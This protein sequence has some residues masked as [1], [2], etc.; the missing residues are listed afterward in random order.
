MMTMPKCSTAVVTS[1]H[2][3][4]PQRKTK[5]KEIETDGTLLGQQRELPLTLVVME[6]G[7]RCDESNVC[8]LRS[9]TYG[10]NQTAFCC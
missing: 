5:P 2:V 1:R 4:T 9:Q 7:D 3:Q 8:E 10:M 6:T